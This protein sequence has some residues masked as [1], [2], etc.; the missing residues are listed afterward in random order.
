MDLQGR[1]IKIKTINGIQYA[2]DMKTVWD[3]ENKKYGKKST[4]L[5]KVADLETMEIIPKREKFPMPK[6]ILNFGDCYSIANT[7]NNS[8]FSDCFNQLLPNEFDTLMSLICYKL[9]KSSSMQYAQTWSEGNYVSQLYKDAD[10]SSQRI[11]DFL[12][13]LGNEAVWRS[14][15]TSYIAKIIGEK[16]GVIVDS[17]GLPNE[18]NFPLSAWGNPKLPTF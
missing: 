9:L 11:S 3:K 12:K 1:K 16:S 5:G 17:T 6:M 4:Y 10:L 18:I 13:K 15:F 7:L 8:V 14:F 2:Y